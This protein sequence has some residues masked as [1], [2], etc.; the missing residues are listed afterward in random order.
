MNAEPSTRPCPLTMR[1]KI[2]RLERVDA[3]GGRLPNMIAAIAEEREPAPFTYELDVVEGR[4]FLFDYAARRIVCIG[5]DADDPHG[6][7]T[8]Y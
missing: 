3:R 2:V 4:A 5:K 6:T 1:A 7:L 8:A